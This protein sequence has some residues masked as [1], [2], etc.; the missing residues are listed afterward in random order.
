[1]A[2]GATRKPACILSAIK[3]SLISGKPWNFF[4]RKR[5]SSREWRA[6]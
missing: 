1:M 5:V 3:A 6:M 2:S 4:G